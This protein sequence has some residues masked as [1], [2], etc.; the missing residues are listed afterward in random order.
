M[1][2][3]IS[4]FLVLVG[5]FIQVATLFPL[6]KLMVMLPADGPL[7]T[8]WIIMAGFVLFFIAGYLGYISLMW[9]QQR[10]MP[11]LIIPS[12]FLVGAIF[13]WQ[14][15]VLTLRTASDIRRIGLLE[16]ENITDPL[17]QVHNRRYMENRLNE[18]VERAARYTLDLSIL[19]LDID[20]FKR[21]ND[22]YG[23]QSGDIALSTLGKLVKKDLRNLDVVARYGGEEFVVICTNTATAG[24]TLVAERLRK[25]IESH[26]IELQHD[27][28]ESQML[29]ISI[30][31]GVAGLGA[32]INTKDKL[33]RA[34]DKALYRAKEEG[35]NRVIIATPIAVPAFAI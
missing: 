22:T 24:A 10:D 26:Q 29:Q 2:S 30:S 8:Q 33:I 28:G 6:R 4:A 27:S 20:H 19:M 5:L 11:D 9:G 1:I 18:E 3:Y 34:A 35:R 25:L 14:T 13:V 23:H 7:R 32:E 17:T 21:V 31:I 12:V 15:I 16:A